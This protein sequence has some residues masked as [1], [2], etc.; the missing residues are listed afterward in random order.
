[1]SHR[2]CRSL[3]L[4]RRVVR[5]TFAVL[6]AAA[7]LGFAASPAAAAPVRDEDGTAH[8]LLDHLL[9][10]WTTVWGSD[11]STSGPT[12]DPVNKPVTRPLAGPSAEPAEAGDGLPIGAD[13]GLSAAG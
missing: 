9:G 10:W 11:G 12:T 5:L 13:R 4:A 7:T 6:L 3:G 8:T 2:T 1:M